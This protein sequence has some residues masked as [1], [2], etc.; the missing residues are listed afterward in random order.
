MWPTLQSLASLLHWLRAMFDKAAAG[1]Q[2]ACGSPYCIH[3]YTISWQTFKV[4]S[5]AS[6]WL[7]PGARFRRKK[8]LH[9]DLS[10]IL[11]HGNMNWRSQDGSR[12]TSLGISVRNRRDRTLRGS[13]T[14]PLVRTFTISR[15]KLCAVN[16]L[17]SALGDIRGRMW[18]WTWRAEISV[19]FHSWDALPLKPL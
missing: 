14:V 4:F 6:L 15:C 7:W 8:F 11:G 9:E 19:H 5:W 12:D 10:S 3:L 17:V 16:E 13:S 2:K 18:P 1:K